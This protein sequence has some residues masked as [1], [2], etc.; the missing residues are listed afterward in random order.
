VRIGAAVRSLELDAARAEQ[1]G[2]VIRRDARAFQA[3]DLARI[4]ARFERAL[5]GSIL[6]E[7]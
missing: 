7:R 4:P 3:S 5:G 1:R 6:F 2:G